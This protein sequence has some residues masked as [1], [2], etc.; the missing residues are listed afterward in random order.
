[1]TVR[2]T[3]VVQ[4]QTA[5]SLIE[6]F[7]GELGY[8]PDEITQR[9]FT[10]LGLS[11]RAQQILRP[12]VRDRVQHLISR[13][14]R[15]QET[16]AAQQRRAAARARAGDLAQ[17][18]NRRKR[19]PQDDEELKLAFLDCA[20]PCPGVPGGMRLLRYFTVEDHQFRIGLHQ[21]NLNGAANRIAGHKWAIR[22]LEKHVAANLD[23]IPRET[24]LAELPS[25]GVTV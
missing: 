14:G 20:V 19:S 24:L 7:Y 1:M 8:S 21:A 6:R 3:P 2:D 15:R 10:E 13:I 17:V 9:L 23:A 5:H 22:E 12:L 4:R 18:M 11:V 25:K 16:F